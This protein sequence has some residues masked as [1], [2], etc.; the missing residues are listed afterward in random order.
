MMHFSG[1]FFT[2]FPELQETDMTCQPVVETHGSAHRLSVRCHRSSSQLFFDEL[3]DQIHEFIHASGKFFFNGVEVVGLGFAIVFAV[4]VAGLAPLAGVQ[5]IDNHGGTDEIEGVDD[6]LV[7]DS[8]LPE[9]MQAVLAF[10]NGDG[11]ADV[12][13]GAFF[14]AEGAFGSFAFKVVDDDFNLVRPFNGFLG[15]HSAGS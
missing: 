3:E 7:I 14:A 2:Q 8:G 6:A 11:L 5:G 4:L 13:Q 9:L 10:E 15:K 12:H 1:R